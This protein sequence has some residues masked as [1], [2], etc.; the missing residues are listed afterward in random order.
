MYSLTY[1]MVC[2]TKL[3][4]RTSLRNFFISHTSKFRSVVAAVC[5]FFP[6]SER[7]FFAW[8]LPETF[9]YCTYVKRP[10]GGGVAN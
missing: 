3:S 1:C 9:E 6:R 5:P 2:Q 4:V 10:A 8:T 7:A